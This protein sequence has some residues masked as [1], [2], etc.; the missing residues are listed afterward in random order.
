MSTI[1]ICCLPYYMKARPSSRSIA[2]DKGREQQ[3]HQMLFKFFFPDMKFG[4]W[5][6]LA[7]FNLC[8]ASSV[9]PPDPFIVTLG[10]CPLSRYI[11][12]APPFFTTLLSSHHSLPPFSSSSSSH[13]HA[14]RLKR[15]HRPPLLLLPP[16]PRKLPAISWFFLACLLGAPLDQEEEAEDLQQAVRPYVMA[17]SP[18]SFSSTAPPLVLFSDASCIRGILF[19][20]MND[21]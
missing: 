16:W 9:L 13:H 14:W 10:H 11:K 3:T 17:L 2:N 8:A 4:C 7:L 18:P 12:T 20:S 5:M 15:Q 19:V 1:P 21:S 6:L